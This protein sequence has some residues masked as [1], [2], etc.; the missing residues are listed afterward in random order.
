[1]YKYD[2]IRDLKR[3]DLVR[4]DANGTADEVYAK[5]EAALRKA[6]VIES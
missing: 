1:M 6:G 4:V 3:D 2:F 5:L